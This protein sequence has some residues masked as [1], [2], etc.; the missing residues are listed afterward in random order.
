MTALAVPR[1]Y[2]SCHRCATVPGPEPYTPAGFDTVLHCAE[3]DRPL[4]EG[5]ADTDADC[6]GDLPRYVGTA[7]C[8]GG[9]LPEEAN[10]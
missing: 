3:C 9:C 2:E 4:C 8:S 6:A 5:C 1:T 10:S 7:R